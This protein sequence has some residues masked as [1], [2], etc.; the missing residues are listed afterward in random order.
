MSVLVKSPLP[1]KLIEYWVEEGDKVS[2]GD[3]LAVVESMKMYNEI[4]SD[5]DGIVSR[6]IAT[7]NSHVPTD[8]DLLE[9]E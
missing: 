2:K 1:G 7:P 3:V 9:I 5:H 4:C 8:S 6:L